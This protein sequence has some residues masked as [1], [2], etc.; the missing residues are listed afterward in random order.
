M[1]QEMND[2]KMN[3][4]DNSNE[5]FEAQF[6]NRRVGEAQFLEV[7]APIFA[8]LTLDV[9]FSE[10]KNLKISIEDN[11]SFFSKVKHELNIVLKDFYFKN[12][13]FVL[14]EVFTQLKSTKRGLHRTLE[15]HETS[16]NI[17][18]R[19]EEELIELYK[20]L[21]THKIHSLT[22]L[23]E[24]TDSCLD[25]IE[26]ETYRT[27]TIALFCMLCAKLKL[28]NLSIYAGASAILVKPCERFGLI[29]TD[30]SRQ[31]IST[32]SISALMKNDKTLYEL[33][34]LLLKKIDKD[35]AIQIENEIKDL[36]RVKKFREDFR[37][38]HY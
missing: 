7:F 27:D 2:I 13:I 26:E 34:E 10:P 19:G 21:I 37:K 12:A 16:P 32:S 11:F 28:F 38:R 22:E 36:V 30:A 31:L 5:R 24:I 17:A 23:I 29:Y 33:T 35:I 20:K 3:V 4:E 6:T 1:A 15:L 18:F 9:N 14:Q 25:R 8:R